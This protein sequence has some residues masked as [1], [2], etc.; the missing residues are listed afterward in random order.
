MTHK[1]SSKF[2]VEYLKLYGSEGSCV[3]AP[4]CGFAYAADICYLVHGHDCPECPAEI[5]RQERWEKEVANNP[6]LQKLMAK[7]RNRTKQLP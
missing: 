4:Y 3:N 2:P 6:K 1:S 7:H 5:K